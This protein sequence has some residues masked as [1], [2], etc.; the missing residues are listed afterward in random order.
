MPDEIIVGNA[1]NDTDDDHIE[2][3]PLAGDKETATG[4]CSSGCEDRTSEQLS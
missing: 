1:G 4:W 3:V 2:S